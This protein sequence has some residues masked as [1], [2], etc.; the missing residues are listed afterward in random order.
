[1]W[2]IYNPPP[3]PLTVADDRQKKLKHVQSICCC[4]SSTLERIRVVRPPTVRRA[5]WKRLFLI[6]GIDIGRRFDD[7]CSCC[8]LT[9]VDTVCVCVRVQHV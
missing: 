8:E 5:M 6:D 7:C 3:C 2:K 4:H 1:M 9:D